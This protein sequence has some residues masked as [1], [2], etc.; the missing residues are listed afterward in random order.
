MSSTLERRFIRLLGHTPHEEI[1]QV[2]LQRVMEL[3]AETNLSLAAI[4]A[5]TG[6]KYP[7]YLCTVFKKKTGLTPGQYRLQ[8]T[9]RRIR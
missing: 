1:I 7:E 4:A 9:G 6:F 8:V 3:L 2:K 5:R